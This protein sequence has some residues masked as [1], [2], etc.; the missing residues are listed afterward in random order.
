LLAAG[1][2]SAGTPPPSGDTELVALTQ[3]KYTSVEDFADR[4]V[5]LEQVLHERNDPR[6]IFAAMYVVLTENGI[7]SIDSGYFEDGEW[8]GAF[9][10]AFGNYYRQAFFDYECGKLDRVPR[11]WRVTFD[12]A[13][14]DEVTVFQ[15]G[16]L[17]VHTHINRDMA[18]A[19]ADVTPPRER[20][21]RYADF[22]RTNDFIV[23]SIDEV[24]NAA[25]AFDS[26][27]GVL[28]ARLGALDEK[29]LK[30]VLS[31]WR[32]RAWRE[33]ATVDLWRQRPA[34]PFVAALRDHITGRQAELF[35]DSDALVALGNAGG[36][37][38]L[39]IIVP[40][41]GK[42]L[43]GGHAEPVLVEMRNG[44]VLQIDLD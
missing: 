35:R 24:E 44:R 29:V 18:Y 20:A 16:L 14:A 2:P 11:P 5:R 38:A 1:F 8:V 19:V 23:A 25:V 4:L 30:H 10:V 42:R 43:A 34:G 13:A 31:R 12:A 15:H 17:G 22:V 21:R 39:R 40:Q 7:E 27:L 33:A 3:S 28:D 9:M 37:L 41:H 36:V 6:A 32:F 26:D